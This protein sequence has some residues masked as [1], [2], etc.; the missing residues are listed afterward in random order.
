V[1]AT[2]RI[3][4]EEA[5]NPLTRARIERARARGHK[6]EITPGGPK[7]TIIFYGSAATRGKRGD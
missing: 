4:E 3:S 5:A 2:W 7:R 1:D 6:V